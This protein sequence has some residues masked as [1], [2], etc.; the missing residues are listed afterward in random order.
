MI[1][2][3]KNWKDKKRLSKIVDDVTHEE[4]TKRDK[5][6]EKQIKKGIEPP[7][8]TLKETGQFMEKV[9]REVLRRFAKLYRSKK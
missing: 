5:E 2:T 1:N 8:I 3:F 4:L 7:D 9:E 6:R